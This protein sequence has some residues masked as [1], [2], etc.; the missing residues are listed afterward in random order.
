MNLAQV[1][2]HLQQR[3]P[4]LLAVYLYGSQAV[5]EADAASDV[6][7]AV[8][9]PGTVDPLLLWALS[10]ELADIV[11]L[12]VDL[13]DLR[14]ASTVMQYQ[15]ITKG[16]LLGSSGSAAGIYEAFVLNQKTE[17]DMAR[18]GLLRDIYEDGVVHGG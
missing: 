15:I 3:L 13:V 14:S 8:L 10:G 1:Y 6:D 18:A 12:P 2:A 7:I 9:V 17:L 4:G 5:G 16:R 11:S